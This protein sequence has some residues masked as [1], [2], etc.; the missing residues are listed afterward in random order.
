[1]SENAAV[2]ISVELELDPLVELY[3]KTRALVAGLLPQSNDTP[4]NGWYST[5]CMSIVK[6]A[7][8]GLLGCQ[9][10]L[11]APSTAARGN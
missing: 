2:W 3:T 11:A 9:R 4:V 5:S 6:D 1:M 7:G 8:S 10:V